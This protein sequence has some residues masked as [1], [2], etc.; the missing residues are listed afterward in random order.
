MAFLALTELAATLEEPDTTGRRVET[1]SR[2]LG[3]RSA[4]AGLIHPCG[5]WSG[6]DTALT[7][8]V[9]MCANQ[10][11]RRQG[12]DPDLGHL[13]QDVNPQCQMKG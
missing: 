5:P 7:G 6:K 9:C 4:G 3:H 10:R 2:V 12:K 1:R 13:P 11:H 8:A